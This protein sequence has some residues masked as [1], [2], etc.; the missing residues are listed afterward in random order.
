MILTMTNDLST[1][2]IEDIRALH[3]HCAAHDGTTAPLSLDARMNHDPNLPA[4]YLGTEEGELVAFLSIFAPDIAEAEIIACVAPQYRRRGYFRAMLQAAQ[5]QL[6]QRGVH[7]LLLQCDAASASGQAAMAA[8]GTRASFSEYS[9]VRPLADLPP[10]DVRL[11]IAEGQMQ[12]LEGISEMAAV[13]FD[14][15]PELYHGMLAKAMATPGMGV[16][17]AAFAGQMVGLCRVIWEED[18]PAI[19]TLGIC[20]GQRGK[21]LGEALLYQV[22]S[23]IRGRGYDTAALEVD[24]GNVPALALYR[25]A[26]FHTR[27]RIDYYEMNI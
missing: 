21:K 17:T 7:R 2:Q 27:S 6:L 15:H 5:D 19:C 11:T 1:E 24:S 3:H 9:M 16:Y 10:V 22:L 13:I 18:P 12:Q 23:Q 26:G 14:G 8:L 25:K 20:P 4:Y